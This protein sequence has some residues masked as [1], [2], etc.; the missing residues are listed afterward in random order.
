MSN[1]T[2]END[3][4]QR[5]VENLTRTLEEGTEEF[6][7]L[8]HRAEVAERALEYAVSEYRCDECPNI[9]CNAEIRGS[10]ECIE[11]ICAEYK[12]EAERDIAEEKQI[13]ID[14]CL[15]RLNEK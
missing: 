4:L 2:V 9:E 10:L 12:K 5:D 1:L 8:Q 15:E 3:V 14:E 6:Q 13:S 11:L 7:E